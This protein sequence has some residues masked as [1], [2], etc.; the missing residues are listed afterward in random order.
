MACKY[1]DK[2]TGLVNELLTDLYGYTDTVKNK[3]V[4]SV[5]KILKN[6][7]VATKV[8]GKMYLTLPNVQTSLRE[9]KRIER[10]HPGLFT[11]QYV[12][13]T[14]KTIWSEAAPLYELFINKNV[15]E[16][17]VP[18]GTANTD[19]QSNNLVD[20]DQYVR[21]VAGADPNTRDYYQDELARR[22]NT[23][24]SKFSAMEREEL[25]NVYRIANHLKS[26]FAIAGV[27]VNVEF[28][29]SI[30]NL[31]QVDAAVEGQ[32]PTIRINP[33]KVR[34]DTTYHE[35][36]H[37]Y[38]DL[39]GVSD[40]V[41]A[42]AIAELRNT[43]L[44]KQVQETYPELYGE[45]LDKEVLATAIGLEGA[46]II[47]K[48][49]NKIQRIL[50]R[51]FR[52]IGKLFG[53]NPSGAA[54]LAEE[55]FAKELRAD[56]MINPLSSYIQASKDEIRLQEL[57]D[58]AKVRINS[59]M[60]RLNQLPEEQVS[61]EERTA[62]LRLQNSLKKV[63]KVEDLFK[64]VDAMGA[65]VARAKKTFK[66]IKALPIK[67]RGTTTNLNKLWALKK[68]T[69]SLE[70]FQ[71][72]KG[73]MLSVKDKGKVQNFEAFERLEDRLQQIL[74]E[75]TVLE[76]DFMF[77]II[78]I[79]AQSVIGLSNKNLPGEIQKIIDNA[80][81]FNRE[82]FLDKRDLMYQELKKRY[83]K[84]ELTDA[85]FKE[86]SV[87][88]KIDQLKQKKLTGYADLVKSMRAGHKDKSSYSYYF[89]PIVYSSDRG[90][91][92]LVKVVQQATL[93]ANDM[94][95]DLK[96][97][98][99]PIYEEFVSG[100]NEN[101]VAALNDAMLEEVNIKGMKRLAFVNP[102][103][104][105]KYYKNLREFKK[106]IGEKYGQP[107]PEDFDG[108]MILFREAYRAWSESSRGRDATRDLV[109]WTK[110]N[111][112][113]IEGWREELAILDK[114]L[115]RENKELKRLK[116]AG[117]QDTQAYLDGQQRRD[118]TLKHRNK[119]FKNGA[120]VGDWVQPNPTVYL[121]PKYTAIQNNPR[122]KK[123]YTF[124]LQQFHQAQDM[125]G[126]KRMDKNSW[127]K[128]SYLMPTYR[129]E[130]YDRA[131]ENGAFNTFS[132]TMKDSFTIQETNH[133][134][135][136]YNENNRDVDYAIPVYATNR[137][138]SRE[139]SKDIAT[140]IYRFRHM[141]HGFKSKSKVSGQVNIFRDILKHAPT[142][143]TTSAGIAVV[144][145]A[146]K[147]MGI[148]MPKLK[149]GESYNYKHVDEWLKSVFF[150][151]SN[152]RKDFTVLG[153]TFS[154][155]QAVSSINAF[156]AMSTLSFN[157]L[158]GANQ[159]ILDNMMMMQ[160]AFA[161]QFMN[162]SDMAWAK[163]QYWG[164]GMAVTDIGRFDPKSKI[165]K[166]VEFFDALT[167]F[168][169]GEGNQLV[170][171]K[172]RKFARTGNL[173]FLQQAAEHELSA[174]RM[175]AIMKNLEGTLKDKTGKV[176]TNEQGNPAN[177]YDLLVVD[178]KTGKMSIDSRLDE[179]QSGFTR[180]D[181]IT[182]LQGIAR[183]TN[184]IKSK[185][186]T[187]MLSRRWYGKLFMLFRNWMPPGIRRRYGH[188]G[189]STL[190]VDEEMG[191]LTQGMYISFWNLITESIS[192]K[193][194]AYGRMTE[195][196]QQ[197]VKRTSVELASLLG[198]MALVA[199][200]ANLDDDEE[201]WI[202][203]FAL[204]Q[205]KRYQTEILQ[206]TPLVGT[207]EAFRILQSPTATTRPILKG[208]ELLGQL[209]SEVGYAVGLGNAKEIFYQRK[210]GRFEKGDRKIRKHFED[211]LPIFRGL[212]KSKTPQEAYKWFTTL[213]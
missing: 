77:D 1:Y 28:D 211:L 106:E 142:L 208:G 49:P 7:R 48:S 135:T 102:I 8:R 80:K 53:I 213:D 78:P 31:G 79:W 155:N 19:L 41:V 88:L 131:K 29:T 75:A 111:S 124:M 87:E 66:E 65:A 97:K 24:N 170:G 209:L 54:I 212:Q 57:V 119:N 129:K 127:D 74:D 180:L 126:R 115:E 35:F 26:S 203:N 43:D 95:L 154:A 17:I 58:N 114:D 207:K 121:N 27:T 128:Y 182:K 174:T 59:E 84:G 12:K 104:Q 157:L 5:Y 146:A 20:I 36:G 195:L 125:I 158:Q 169:D 168:T 156:T 196:E 134:Y 63:K 191:V 68:T 166:A 175:L 167:E 44:Y 122:L 45:L 6:R 184:Q 153:K 108:D 181:F 10:K 112:S 210:T 22:E 165:G 193:S 25:E 100:Q 47:S 42:K 4:E 15:L 190:H 178:K 179:E 198:A 69:D 21:F 91:Q 81:E 159:S 98:L 189:G 113:E 18:E 103:D 64:L 46:K 90:I 3:N 101:S 144:Q 67:D 93:E 50:N 176:I 30:D 33:E 148:D 151:E 23:S 163:G 71:S 206:W 110:E 86:K 204:Y 40:P 82:V 164:S 147:N 83:R 183:R 13:M 199:A 107:K 139:I 16:N 123:Y 136:T 138:P 14:P 171:G 109:Q 201:S 70:M 130:D 186:H 202:S 61:E 120:A 105:E 141:A 62:M 2:K 150:G 152:I 92:L 117:E 173:L 143:E 185:M 172:L 51:L 205:A 177:L 94:T 187:N 132:D 11:T 72:I 145:A 140:S 39:L 89:D 149:D 133:D 9:L 192:E 200:L 85:E 55:M 73:L 118:A 161:G 34:K 99:A 52:A 60:Y 194:F 76:G 162:K 96:S 116:L 160:E 188:G 38:I 32:N 137:V 197:N 37:I 56:S